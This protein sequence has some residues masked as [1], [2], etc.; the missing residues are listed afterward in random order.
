VAHDTQWDVVIAIID[1]SSQQGFALV[2]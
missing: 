2:A 1:H